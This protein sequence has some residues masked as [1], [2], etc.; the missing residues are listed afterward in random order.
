LTLRLGF[1]EWEDTRWLVVN[2]TYK[3]ETEKYLGWN[4]HFDWR[5]QEL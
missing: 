5:P 2:P 4:D 1:N 3:T